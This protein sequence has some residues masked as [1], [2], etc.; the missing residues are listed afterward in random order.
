M[1]SNGVCVCVKWQSATSTAPPS[2]LPGSHL[3]GQSPAHE[4]H[5]PIGQSLRC[6][7]V[8]VCVCA[9]VRV[10]VVCMYVPTYVSRK[11]YI[12]SV[13]VFVLVC[14]CCMYISRYRHTHTHTHTHTHIHTHTHT[15][16]GWTKGCNEQTQCQRL[17][18]VE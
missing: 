1:F 10:C 15:H 18:H 7:F 2:P 5:T 14:V 6:V 8:C 9:R 16:T 4:P 12:Y 17:H 11:G 3:M 13:C